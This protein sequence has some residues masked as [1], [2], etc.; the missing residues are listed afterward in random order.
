MVLHKFKNIVT[1]NEADSLAD[2]IISANLNDESGQVYYNNSKGTSD[3]P[4]SHK[5]IDRFTGLISTVYKKPFKF[6]HTYSR[7]Y[8]NGSF[9]KIHTD[10]EGLDITISLCV[11]IEAK[12]LWPLSVSH[13]P[14]VGPWKHDLDFDYYRKLYTSITLDKCD[15][16]LM[17][18][19]IYPHWRDDL[20]C[21][22]EEK[23][24]YIFYHWTKIT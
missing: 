14:H 8:S 7:I 22:P 12:M 18:G 11:R 20:I 13:V 21:S 4:E 9:L 19:I 16:A 10:R 23:N 6:S 5:Y 24:I 2:A 1:P 3:I 15:G 17:E